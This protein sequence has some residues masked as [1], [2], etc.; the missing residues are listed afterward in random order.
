MRALKIFLISVLCTLASCSTKPQ[1]TEDEIANGLPSDTV[2]LVAKGQHKT[3]VHNFFREKQLETMEDVSSNSI[4]GITNRSI[5]WVG[6][7]WDVVQCRFDER[8]RLR[9]VLMM[10]SG[11]FDNG[12]IV[13]DT[14][15]SVLYQLQ[16]KFGM[17][18]CVSSGEWYFINTHNTNASMKQDRSTDIIVIWE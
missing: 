12:D 10:R 14:T 8:N 11:V 4:I 5:T 1:H 6:V 18:K 16:C 3:D 15:M 9:S 17:A 13:G 7:D 2:W